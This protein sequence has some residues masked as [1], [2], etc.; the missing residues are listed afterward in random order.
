[1]DEKLVKFCEFERWQ[2]LFPSFLEK[3]IKPSVLVS[4]ANPDVRRAL[5]ERIANN[6]YSIGIP[7]ECE[8]PK[9]NGD[10]RKVLVLPDLDRCIMSVILDVYSEFYGDLI[11]SNCLS[12]QKGIGTPMILRKVHRCINAGTPGWKLDI[13]KYFDTVPITIIENVFKSINTDSAIDKLLWDFYHDNRVIRNGEV[14]EYYKSLGQGCAFGSFLA[15]V[16]LRSIDDYASRESEIYYRYSDDMIVLGDNC[17]AVVK[18]IENRLHDL[19]LSIKPEKRQAINGTGFDFL[20]GRVDSVGVGLTRKHRTILRKKIRKLCYGSGRKGQKA[21]IKRIQGWLFGGKEAEA[22]YQF[23]LIT[24]ES[25]IVWLDEYCKDQLKAIF[26]GKQNRI[27]NLRKTSNECLKE[28]GWFSLVAVWREYKRSK[29]V[30]AARKKWL[31]REICD[32][33]EISPDRAEELWLLARYYEGDTYLPT[34]PNE[35]RVYDYLE[36]RDI[37]YAAKELEQHTVKCTGY[38]WQSKKFPELVL[39]RD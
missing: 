39:F 24:K 6:E 12:Y 38:Y 19:G 32:R 15:N 30:Y 28:L 9:D 36:Y 17:D 11:H 5:A 21:S 26:T 18:G 3:G 22:D 23:N 13:S 31:F 33:S 4:L 10:T 29:F 7:T 16:V 34:T 2:K 37:M 1:M 27:S 20:G 35:T 8:I 14:C 25:D